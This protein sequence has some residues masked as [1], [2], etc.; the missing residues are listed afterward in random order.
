MLLWLRWQSTSLVRMRSPVRIWLA[1][2]KRNTGKSWC[3]F[4]YSWYFLEV[5]A[6]RGRFHLSASKCSGRQKRRRPEG[7][8][9]D[10]ADRCWYVKM[11][12]LVAPSTSPQTSYRS[13]RRFLFIMKCYRFFRIP[14][15]NPL[16][17]AR[18]CWRFNLPFQLKA[19]VISLALSFS[20]FL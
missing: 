2:P 14:S 16:R 12:T 10:P 4:V 8:L 9:A 3:F 1:A 20:I 15:R 11:S 7:R 17:W 5:P 18:G 6:A 19:S 13:R